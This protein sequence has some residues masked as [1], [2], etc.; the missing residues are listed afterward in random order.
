MEQ[1]LSKAN[2]LNGNGNLIVKSEENFGE[3]V[4]TVQYGV[5]KLMGDSTEYKVSYKTLYDI[6][7]KPP[8]FKG[9]VIIPELRLKVP[10]SNIVFQQFR[11]KKEVIVKDF[12]KLPTVE[13]IC[14]KDIVDGEFE[15]SNKSIKELCSNMEEYW[16]VTA[17]VLK[18]TNTPDLCFNHVKQALLLKSSEP[19]YPASIL[20]IYKYG[21]LQ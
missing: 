9:S 2:N 11:E 12:A 10:L 6:A 16:R 21:K 17:H 18:E 13:L 14:K 8:Q 1:S 15:V 20:K 4:N 5:I 7:S 19:N 3:V